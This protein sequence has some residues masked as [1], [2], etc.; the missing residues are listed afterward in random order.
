MTVVS[1]VQYVIGMSLKRVLHINGIVTEACPY[2]TV[3]AFRKYGLYYLCMKRI[4]SQVI[5]TN[6]YVGLSF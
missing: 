5:H 1:L 3:S 4:N 6:L 2:L